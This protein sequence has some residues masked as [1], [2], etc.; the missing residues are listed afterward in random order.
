MTDV[1]ARASWRAAQLER[2][3]PRA[4]VRLTRW[5]AV[6]W[7]R[8]GAAKPRSGDPSPFRQ[9]LED[10]RAEGR[11]E[12]HAEGRQEGYNAGYTD[13]VVAGRAQES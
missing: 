10:G 7:L 12:G 5:A 13:G 1:Q 9:G 8:S 6:R 11:E 3:R 2:R 4:R